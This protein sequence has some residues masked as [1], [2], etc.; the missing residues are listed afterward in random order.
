VSSRPANSDLIDF[1]RAHYL[2]PSRTPKRRLEYRKI[3]GRSLQA[4]AALLR[5]AP[6]A[7][8]LLHPPRIDPRRSR[9]HDERDKL[10]SLQAFEAKYINFQRN[11]SSGFAG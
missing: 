3:A 7:P 5:G 2:L 4:A 8:I 6:H 11:R 9:H 1:G 10:N